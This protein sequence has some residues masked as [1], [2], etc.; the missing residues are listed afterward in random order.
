M[1]NRDR[2]MKH[3]LLV[4][5]GL[6]ALCWSCGGGPKP[7]EVAAQ[8]ARTYYDL[9]IHGKFDQFVDGQYRPDSIP[10]SYREQLIANAKMFM[11]EQ[12][13]TH[14]GLRQVEVLRVAPDSAQHVVNVFLIFIYGNSTKEEV[15][16][17]MVEHNGVWY[18]R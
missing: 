9:L 12:E 3:A 6:C 4:A 5:I 7:E 18:M 1:G 13:K 11:G 14:N 2:N 16:V 15:V 10:L 8:A 17:P